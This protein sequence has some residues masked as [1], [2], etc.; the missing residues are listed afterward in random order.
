LHGINIDLNTMPD[1]L[2]ALAVTACYAEGTTGIHNVPQARMKETDRIAVMA[3]ELV[4][5]GAHIEELEDG[6]VINRSRLK[7]AFLHGCHDHRVVM[8]LAIASLGAEGETVIDTAEAASVT[9]PGFFELLDIVK[10]Q[11]IKESFT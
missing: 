7:G 3:E 5:I 10:K 6:L 1:A 2:P 9:F 8:A 11:D 4:K